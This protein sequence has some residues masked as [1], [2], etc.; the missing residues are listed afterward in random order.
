MTSADPLVQLVRAEIFAI[1]PG[2]PFAHHRLRYCRSALD[3]IAR[4]ER[5]LARSAIFD[6]W[7]ARDATGVELG[8][9]AMTTAE[10]HELEGLRVSFEGAAATASAG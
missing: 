4:D 5:H 6:A 7:A 3:A 8:G 10:A 9:R 1:D 2:S